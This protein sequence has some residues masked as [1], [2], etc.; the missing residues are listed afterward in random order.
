MNNFSSVFQ[1]DCAFGF[2]REFDFGF[3]GGLQLPQRA[4]ELD[5]AAVVLLLVTI[6]LITAGHQSTIL[7]KTMCR[8]GAVVAGVFNNLIA[9]FG[10]R[11]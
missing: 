10:L 8:L 9:N 7:L 6:H 5:S 2:D 4:T 11:V 1:F 3:G